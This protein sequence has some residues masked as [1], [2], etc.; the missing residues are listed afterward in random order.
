MMSTPK[1]VLVVDDDEN[2]VELILTALSRQDFQCEPVVACDGA[3][4]LDY[5]HARGK[6]RGRN[7][8]QPAVVLLDL[9]MPR[10]DGFAFL[11][12][13]R[14]SE[15]LKMIPAVVFTSSSDE[16]DRLKSYELGANAYV[17]KPV[18]FEEFL[19]VVQ[20]VGRF[21]AVINQ[22]V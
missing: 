6:F 2:N 8:S 10:V 20:A 19:E 4:A 5:L 1:R 15:T 17:V 18:D 11:R 7:G 21:W 12:E 22:T 16:R 13:L 14:A 3:Q 9:K